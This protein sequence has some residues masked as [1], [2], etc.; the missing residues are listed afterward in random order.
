MRSTFYLTEK[1]GPKQSLTPEGFLLCADV[2]LARIGMMIYGPNE[3]PIKAGPEGIVKIMREADD[4]F[5][6]ETISS[7]QGKPVTNDHPEED[8]TP[9]NWKELCHGTMLNVRRG[10]GMLDDLMIGDL[11]VTTVEGIE[12]VRSGKVE[13]S[14]GYEAD[15]EE[16][17]PGVGKQTN[18]IINHIALVDQ[19]RCGPRCAI[20]DSKPIQLRSESMK[21]KSNRMLDALMKAFRAKDANEVEELAKKVEDEFPETKDA[22]GGS[23]DTHIHIHGNGTISGDAPAVMDE[24][25]SKEGELEGA[26]SKDDDLT[27]FKEQNASEHADMVARITALETAIAAMKGTDAAKDDES[28]VPAEAMDEFSEEVKEEAAKAKD[29]KYFADSF[30]D[31]VAMAE[32]LAPGIRVPTFDSVQKPGTTFKKI[33]NLR[34]QALDLAYAQPATRGIVDDILDGKE[35]NTKA[36]T[37]DAVRTLFKAAASVQRK[38]NNAPSA[39]ATD[40]KKPVVKTAPRSLAEL[41]RLNA[42]K[43]ST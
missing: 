20:S 43:Y 6:P 22:E 33:C 8:V 25:G 7:A 29:S 16:T 28:E 31:T 41:N 23:G 17:A 40:T 10:E 18:I 9:D 37:C 35:L 21:T 12:A 36:M 42:A 4:V 38:T 30:Q 14:L 3:T 26:T 19:G 1:L 27:A 32:I 11:L 24:E 34:R 5:T 15:Y 2:P 13:V 39:R